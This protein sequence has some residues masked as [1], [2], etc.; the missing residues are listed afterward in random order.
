MSR[1]LVHIVDDDPAVRDSL[2]LLLDVRGFET[3][4]YADA[5]S[6][7]EQCD[8]SQPGCL[9]LD[10]RMPGISGA[11]L[12]SELQRR[13]VDMPI[14]I[15]T[16]HGDV[17]ATRAAFRAG[18]IDFI[19]KPIDPDTIVAAVE[20]ALARG[21]AWRQHVVRTEE[22]KQRLDT[23]TGRE[24]QVIDRTVAGRHNREI[25]SELGISA[26]TVEVYKARAMEKLGVKRI[27]DLV[28]LALRARESPPRG[29]EGIPYARSRMTDDPERD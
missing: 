14:L 23:L 27:P 2:G 16:A 21:T 29:G 7:L 9:V 22:A 11:E 26:R 10:L 5:A 1:P 6:F 17:S 4:V 25:A 12:Q 18:A 24:R 19:E 28:R 20:D 13:E 3:R 8:L 15:V